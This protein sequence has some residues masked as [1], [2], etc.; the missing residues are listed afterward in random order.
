MNKFFNNMASKLKDAN[1]FEVSLFY[2]MREEADKAI[3]LLKE[4]GIANCGIMQLGSQEG[5]LYGNY[6]TIETNEVQYMDFDD[7][8]IFMV[9]F[10]CKFTK[11]FR[12]RK[13]LKEAGIWD[14]KYDAIGYGLK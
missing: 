1:F 5:E 14:E 13:R 6:R 12:I 3:Q 4:E 9:A 7:E 8:V 10:E 2:G 11:F